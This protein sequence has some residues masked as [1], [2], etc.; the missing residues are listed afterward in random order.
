MLILNVSIKT[1]Q[2]SGSCNKINDPYAKRC[3]PNVVKNLNIKVFNLMSMTND[4]RH[5]KWHKT[6]KCKRRLG[7]S[8]CNN[9]QCWNGDKC[10]CHCKELIDKGVCDKKLIW[11]PSNCECECDKS[12]DTV[13]Y[14]DFENCNC[15]KKLV[16]RLI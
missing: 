9:K 1:S 4:T 14:L 5:I 2:C 15:R 16:D 7:A 13:E 11:N 12:C 6:C 3:V 8:V 10:I